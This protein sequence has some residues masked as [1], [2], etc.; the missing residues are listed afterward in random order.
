M[1]RPHDPFRVLAISGSLRA[2]S[3]NAALLGAA[4]LA[5]PAGVEV[6]AY[7]DLAALPAFNPDLDRALGD[8]ALPA[9]VRDLRARVS[10]AD[11]LLISSPEYAHGPPGA[12]KNA[13]DWLVGGAEV[14]GMPVALLNA[15]AHATHAQAALA[16]TLRTMSARLV[17]AACVTVDMAARPRDAVA[18]AADPAVAGALRAVLAAL[19]TVRRAA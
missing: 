5:A 18:L 11:A 6:V 2:G 19:A 10:A 3:S 15:S 13:L 8:P 14:P 4:A 16:E 9:T 7:D 17:D 12:L 1:T